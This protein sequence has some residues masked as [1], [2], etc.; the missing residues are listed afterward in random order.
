MSDAEINAKTIDD[1]KEK[2]EEFQKNPASY[3]GAIRKDYAWTQTI[4]DLD[5]QV[6]VDC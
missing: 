6:K 5:V 3:N 2:Q 4:K 1:A